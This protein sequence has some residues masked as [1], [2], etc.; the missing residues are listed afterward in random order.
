A[1]GDLDRMPHLI[2]GLLDL[3]VAL[4]VTPGTP[5]T[6]IAKREAGA[7]PIV[8]VV[9]DPVGAGF[10]NSLARPGG[11]ITGLS[12]AQDEAFAGKLLE[13][14]KET[15][16]KTARV[17]LIWNPATRSNVAAVAYAA[18]LTAYKISKMGMNVLGQSL[19][20]SNAKH[21]IR[22]NT[23]MPGLMDTPM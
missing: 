11:T 3:K 19:A 12:I 17:G 14:V 13:L 9:N 20:L 23:I 10:A 1:G 8:T 18:P 5:V 2:A 21:G 16:P 22:V 15:L 6:A 7:T 4:L